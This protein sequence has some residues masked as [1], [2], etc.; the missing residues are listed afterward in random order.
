[1]VGA[2][3]GKF[4]IVAAL[5]LCIFLAV[6]CGDLVENKVREEVTEQVAEKTGEMATE[7]EQRVEEKVS[8]TTDEMAAQIEEQ[9]N[10]RVTARVSEMEKQIRADVRKNY[11]EE[12]VALEE[13]LITAERER[14][15]MEKRL[16]SS[17]ESGRRWGSL[18]RSALLLLGF[19]TLIKLIGKP[20]LRVFACL[21]LR[22]VSPNPRHIL[23]AQGIDAAG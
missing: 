17:E 22:S 23:K 9:I 15:E 10:T 16:S 19:L 8:E 12:K 21:L 4:C 18:I 2:T 11:Q 1:M 6:G 13:R 14:G 20:M 5:A 3:N 7:V